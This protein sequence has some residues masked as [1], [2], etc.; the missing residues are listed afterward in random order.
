MIVSRFA[1]G[2]GNQMFQ[3]AAGLA[4]SIRKQAPLSVDDGWFSDMG[5][6]TPRRCEITQFPALAG[7][8]LAIASPS[9]VM[10]LRYKPESL[11]PRMMR[12]LFRKPRAHS[13]HHIVE[14]Q[15]APPVNLDVYPLPI[16][17]SGYWQS[18]RYFADQAAAIREAF[19][20]PEFVRPEARTLARTILCEEESVSLHVRRGDYVANPQANLYHGVCGMTYYSRAMEIVEQSVPSPH[21]VIF[22]D[23]PEWCRTAF[24][25]CGRTMTVV[26]VHSDNDA[27]HDMHLMALCKH[28]IIANSS[29][30]WWGAWLSNERGMTCAP[31][32]WFAATEK[33]KDNPSP[34]RWLLL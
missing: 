18:E 29:F 32:Q 30:S 14:D 17:L 28:H 31:R 15:A 27:I 4:L 6:A 12:K 33:E 2:L 24:A 9:L 7:G 25:G 26:D 10:R 3:Y 16:Y 23:D 8:G 13:A 34:D 22:S 20:F 19:T 5:D 11:L 1:G 21:Y